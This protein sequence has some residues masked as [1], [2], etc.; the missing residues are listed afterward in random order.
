MEG[1]FSQRRGGV[2]GV[3]EHSAHRDRNRIVAIVLDFSLPER[4]GDHDRIA[5]VDGPFRPIMNVTGISTRRRKP[6]S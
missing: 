3:L 6:A 5:A 2:E 1:L 4:I